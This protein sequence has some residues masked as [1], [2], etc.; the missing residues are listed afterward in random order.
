VLGE[1]VALSAKQELSLYKCIQ[2]N[3]INAYGKLFPLFYSDGF[4][5][6]VKYAVGA[7]VYGAQAS[8]VES[9]QALKK[10]VL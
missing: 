5:L 3:T 7:F 4:R 9:I 1:G 8:L 10:K 6:L 2:L